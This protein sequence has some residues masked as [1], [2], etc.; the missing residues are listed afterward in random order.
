MA[1]ER[2]TAVMTDPSNPDNRVDMEWTRRAWEMLARGELFVEPGGKDLESV[3][4]YGKCP[5]CG[6]QMAYTAEEHA[7]VAALPET[8]PKP[9]A[10][11]GQPNAEPGTREVGPLRGIDVFCRC[12]YPHDGHPPG[13]AT[14][15]G[16][17]FRIALRQLP[18]GVWKPVPPSTGPDRQAIAQMELWHGLVEGS[19]ERTA[20]TARAWAAGLTGLLT[21]LVSA[22]VISG[23][24]LDKI[25]DPLRAIIVALV[26]TGVALILVGLVYVML[27]QAPALRLARREGVLAKF[28]SRHHYE[29][30]TSEAAIEKLAIARSCVGFGAGFVLVG[31][32]CWLFARPLDESNA[33]LV[34]VQWLQNGQESTLCGALIHSD[35]GRV[36]IVPNE[37]SG[38]V[39]I[40]LQDVRRLAP[41]I[42]CEPEDH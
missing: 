10:A 19:S 26:M 27:A 31:I 8:G 21:F 18:S 14:G 39:S 20:S 6:D 32:S 13:E 36:L 30:K 22:V 1:S 25:A 17:V 11:L 35:A 3:T 34:Q 16:A 38:S 24:T 40:P 12:P 2:G 29:M 37:L 5:R 4:V 9:Q 41:V 28:A 7:V 15:C 23:S 33:P 42:A